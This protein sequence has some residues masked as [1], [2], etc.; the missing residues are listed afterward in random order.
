VLLMPGRYDVE[1]KEIDFFL[2]MTTNI[3][4]LF[5][6]ILYIF[7]ILF[8]QS[9]PLLVLVFIIAAGWLMLSTKNKI[10]KWKKKYG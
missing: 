8:P 6:F 4:L 7:S 9:V 5:A 3:L 1:T 10:V 2:K